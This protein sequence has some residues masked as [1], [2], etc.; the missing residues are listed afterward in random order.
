MKKKEL[1]PRGGKREA[2]IEGR[3]EKEANGEKKERDRVGINTCA[4][5]RDR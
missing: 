4:C 5:R 2:E 3:R 1:D